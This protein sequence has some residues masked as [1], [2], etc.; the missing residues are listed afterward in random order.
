MS[1]VHFTI[2]SRS[3]CHLCDE[4]FQALET[5]RGQHV[6]TVEMIDVDSDDRLLQRYDELVPVLVAQRADQL[7]VQLCH[8]FLDTSRVKEYLLGNA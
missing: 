1:P 8:H 3:Y 5:I 6:F 2:Y 7:P 4:M